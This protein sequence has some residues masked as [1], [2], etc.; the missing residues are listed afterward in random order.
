[1]FKSKLRG[2]LEFG[3]GLSLKV[4]PFIGRAITDKLSIFVYHDITENPSEFEQAWGLAVSNDTFHRQISWI[5]N[6]FNII[7]PNDLINGSALPD[8]A[9]LISFDD[10]FYGAFESGIP[11]LVE[12]SIPSIIFLNMRSVIE[13]RPLISAIAAF[14]ELYVPTFK[15]FCANAGLKAPYFLTLTPTL[16]E[17]Y[18]E[19]FGPIDHSKVKNFQGK[20][21]SYPTV[22]KWHNNDLIVFGNHLFDHWNSAALSSEEFIDQFQR[23]RL[24]LKKLNVTSN[25]F[26]FPNGQPGTCFDDR[27]IG[28]LNEL[29]ANK[30]FYSGGTTVSDPDGFLLGRVGLSEVDVNDNYLWFRMLRLF[31]R[32]YKQQDYEIN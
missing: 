5:S 11:Y 9:A 19:Q 10:G 29:K 12:R 22:K 26:A 31:L 21:A 14:L 24:A 27:E 23:N 2:A 25:L 18:E 30:I 1:M 7:H 28:L 17:R 13:N 4:F 6:N 20:F 16:L 8:R 3:F 15:K 32:R